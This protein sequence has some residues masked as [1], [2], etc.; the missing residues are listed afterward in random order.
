MNRRERL[1]SQVLGYV[2]AAV[3]V[4]ALAWSLWR[5]QAA[6]APTASAPD[7][8]LSYVMM[9]VAYALASDGAAG[10]LTLG[11]LEA[12]PEVAGAVG[13]VGIGRA[14][15]GARLRI[16][17]I[18]LPVDSRASP[19]QPEYTAVAYR[20]DGLAVPLGPLTLMTSQRRWV[21]GL[22]VDPAWLP[23]RQIAI[24]R[25]GEPVMQASLEPGLQEAER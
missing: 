22:T 14:G 18:G 8:R 2:A 25:W 19:L 15:S 1:A 13:G 20:S 7:R 4:L 11:R 3:L 16:L 17:V 12:L 10:P 21:L 5:W 23:I 6:G 9:Q 24:L